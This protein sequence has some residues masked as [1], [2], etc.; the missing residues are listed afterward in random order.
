MKVTITKRAPKQTNSVKLFK[1]KLDQWA[2]YLQDVLPDTEDLNWLRSVEIEQLEKIG[3]HRYILQSFQYAWYRT[4]REAAFAFLL[5]FFYQLANGLLTKDP[6]DVSKISKIQLVE[7]FS[8]ESSR[9]DF[10]FIFLDAE[11]NVIPVMQTNQVVPQELF[12][13]DK[14]VYYLDKRVELEKAASLQ[15]V[16]N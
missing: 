4:G 3:D 11:D 10:M 1:Q 15:G 14:I 16:T 5:E 7:D 13:A 12:G 2:N 6:I 9:I 8:P